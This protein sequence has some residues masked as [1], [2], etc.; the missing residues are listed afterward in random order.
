MQN[1]AYRASLLSTCGILAAVPLLAQPA[2]ALTRSSD[3]R[4]LSTTVESL[5]RDVSPSVVQILVTGYRQVDDGHA[6]E[7]GLVLGRQRALGAGAIVDSDGY[8]ITAAHLVTGA[9]RVQVVL[10]DRQDNEAASQLLSTVHGQTK[11]ARIVGTS[12]DFDLAVLKIDAPMLPALRFADYA[13]VRQG[14]LVLAFGSP[15]GLANTVT[16][17]VVSAVARQPDPDAPAVY[18]QTDAPINLG[19]SGGPLV[20]VNGRIVGIVTSILS[21]SGGSQGIGFAVPSAIV[22]VVYAQL[23]EFGQVHRGVIGIDVQA[24]TPA[25]AEALALARPSGVVVSDVRPD[26]PADT[27]GVQVQDVVA[28][29]ND[30][31]IDSVPMFTL[32]LN[33]RSVGDRLRLGLLRGSETVSLEVPVI[34]SGIGID[35][36]AHLADPVT[37]AVRQLGIVGIDITSSTSTLLPGLRIASGVLVAA[38]EQT[39]RIADVP[40][41]TGDVIHA[42]NGFAVRSLDGLR[43]LLQGLRDDHPIVVQI[44]RNGQLMFRTVQFY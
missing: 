33:K 21:A 13:K 1:I 27:A 8:I 14:E 39:G 10:N 3:P 4:E 12:A 40:L 16:M 18:L 41:V 6:T 15:D 7:P 24:I 29:M 28:T 34:A 35:Q 25:M 44:E 2:K 37:N 38:R 9:E 32:K 36:L 22:A 20:D 30:R 23:R 11:D 43:V 42:V 5:S 31:P 19:N 26:S 17:G